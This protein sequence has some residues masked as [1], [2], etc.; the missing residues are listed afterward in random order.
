MSSSASRTQA[1]SSGLR[2]ELCVRK[3][4]TSQWYMIKSCTVVYEQNDAA[5][6]V[7]RLQDA[8]PLLRAQAGA[9]GQEIMHSTVV[10]DDEVL[11]SG[12]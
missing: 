9:L 5:N 7:I 1:R 8:G 3:S 6:I 4:C 10:Y 2:P 12:I 11:H